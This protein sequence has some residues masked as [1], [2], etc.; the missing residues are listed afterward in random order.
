M[1][2]LE[3]IVAACGGILLDGGARALIPGPNHSHKDRSVS[4]R[5]TEEGRI[6]IHCFSPKDDWRDVRRALADLGL[7]DDGPAAGT[8]GALAPARK[9]AVQPADEERTARAQ[10]IWDES[11]PLKHTVAEAYLRRRAIPPGLLQSEA[12]RFHPRMTSLDDR[13]RRP[14]LV[15]A[16]TNDQG[17]LQG[18]Q[19]TLLSAHG[20]AKAAL[21]T[22]RRV[23]GKLLGG[24]VR[25]AEAHTELVIG[26]LAHAVA[27]TARPAG[28]ARRKSSPRPVGHGL[29]SA[30]TART[31]APPFSPCAPASMAGRFKRRRGRAP[32]PRDQPGTLTG[33][34]L[35][36]N[37]VTLLGKL[38][39][40]PKSA[41]SKS[42]TA[43]SKSSRS[44]SKRQAAN[45]PTASPSRSTARRPRPR[46][47]RCAPASSPRSP[48]S[49]VTTAGRTRLPAN[50][51]ARCSSP[52]I[53]AKARSSRLAWPKLRPPP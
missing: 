5:L 22:P 15:A 42:A 18:V 16:I 31:R 35:M 2:R 51:P 44:G 3:R 41:P 27:M 8:R 11:G 4:L 53:P 40:A 52:S 46:R 1:S 20:I 36:T 7:L 17:A 28:R 37:R 19:V 10:R 47:K 39:D 24:A 43:P 12:L 49:C 45:A 14:A 50:G 25:I 33:V 32:R 48:A 26:E 6:L 30:R 38:V 21:A 23:I 13:A 29:R 34:H 9:F